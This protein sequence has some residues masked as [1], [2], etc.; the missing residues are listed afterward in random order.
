MRQPRP[1]GLRLSVRGRRRRDWRI[2]ALEPRQLLATFTVDSTG[3]ADVPGTLRWAINQANLNPGFDQIDFNIPGAGPHTITPATPLP[4]ITDRVTID[5][6][7][8]G[9]SSTPLIILDGSMAGSGANGLTLTGTGTS[10]ATLSRIVGLNIHSFDVAG[11]AI[12][13]DADNI[14]IETNFIGTNDTGTIAQPNQFGVLILNSSSNTIGGLTSTARNLISGNSA[15]GVV[16]RG[17]SASS[18]AIQGNLIGPALD[19]NTALLVQNAGIVVEGDGTANSGA[20]NNTIGGGID[21]ARNIISGNLGAGITIQDAGASGNSIQRNLIGLNSSGT[22]PLPNNIG[23]LLANG[24]SGNSIG[25]ASLTARNVISTNTLAD[26][27]ID[28]S[29]NNLVAGN[30]IGTN[31]DGTSTP[32]G[33]TPNLGVW[34]DD[35]STGNTIG[36]STPSAGNV[37]SGHDIAGI[38]ISDATTSANLVQGNVIGTAVGGSAPIPNG[39]GILLSG[40]TTAN[41]IGGLTANARNIISGNSSDGIQIEDDGTNNHLI[42]GNLIG[43][44]A[45]AT[46]PLA[47]AGNGIRIAGGSNNTIG[48]SATGAANTIANNTGSG[49]LVEVGSAPGT[50]QANL[51]SRNSIFDNGDLGIRL[52]PGANGD[53]VPPSLS[54]ATTT[55]TTTTVAGSLTSTPSTTFTIEFYANDPPGDPS[56]AGQGQRFLGTTTV[57]TDGSGFASFSANL[58]PAAADGQLISALA[59]VADPS[60]PPTNG[61]T[62][63]FA[64]NVTNEEV[65]ADL[66][67]TITAAATPPAPS[68]QVPTSALFTYTITVSNQGDGPAVAV[69]LANTIPTGTS[70]V[71]G[72]ASQGGPLSQTGSVINVPLG[73]LD[74]GEEAT[75]TITIVS[76]ASIPL[77]GTI[78]NTATATTSTSESS[79]TNNTATLTTNVVQGIDLSVTKVASPAQPVL[80]SEFAY[81]VT[82]T[83]KSPVPAT[84]V[85][86]TDTLPA[87]VVFVS[88]TTTQGTVSESAGVVTA[89][90]G[91]LPPT[92]VANPQGASAQITIIVRPTAVG[93][94]TNTATATADQLQNVAGDNV[95]VL[96]SS[97]GT[98][99]PTPEGQ[100]PLVIRAARAGAGRQ[101]TRFLISFSQPMDP[102]S[103]QRIANYV[104]TTA[105]RDGRFGTADDRRIRLGSIRYDPP[106]RTTVLTAIRPVSLQTRLRLRVIGRPP[107]GLRS[108]DGLFLAGTN[109]QTGTDFV[110]ILRGRTPVTP[111]QF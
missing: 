24:A 36:G 80:D 40:G 67:V 85:V 17:A 22:A 110:T 75:I 47:N 9:S 103:T 86:L 99:P 89:N 56:G 96:T 19:G 29:D 2:E 108:A 14:A 93:G 34:I 57:T 82:V 20:R 3:D 60:S 37:I 32:G 88:A 4:P 13:A 106:T 6:T 5:G 83:N 49:I 87:G 84:N 26:V 18:N 73:T 38:Q 66:V 33:S 31:S 21:A 72:T 62:S 28:D 105:G 15:A 10:T 79:T 102:S 107:R 90:L 11:I 43:L 94:I 63:P 16:L 46:T 58:S 97:V 69:N 35:G 50:G 41:T 76:P 70:F 68:G 92:S 111:T 95:A 44:A 64:V 81:I 101:Q 59:I 7:T 12:L 78:S 8:Q 100:A 98:I 65:Q 54:S 48:G 104:V 23:V 30:L 25:F 55:G 39:V 61:N 45:D 1:V 77:S 74:P 52:G 109:G 91:T 53:Q 27:L 51:L 71:G 42:Q